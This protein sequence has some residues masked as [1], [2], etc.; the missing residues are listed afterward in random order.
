MGE[1]RERDEAETCG[2]HPPLDR[3]QAML[4]RKK[5]SSLQLVMYVKDGRRAE[6]GDS[7]RAACLLW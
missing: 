4:H 5:R 6:D 3:P 2:L 1:V 7:G